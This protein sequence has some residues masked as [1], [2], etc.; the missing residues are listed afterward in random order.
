[1]TILAINQALALRNNL[2]QE[3]KNN[4]KRRR[5]LKAIVSGKF[6]KSVKDTFERTIYERAKNEI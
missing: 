1:M 5:V 4:S 2:K 6:Q 3:F